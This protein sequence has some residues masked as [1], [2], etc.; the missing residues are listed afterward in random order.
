[1]A[2]S[3]A[4]IGLCHCQTTSVGERPSRSWKERLR[5]AVDAKPEMS[6]TVPTTP[7]CGALDGTRLEPFGGVWAEQNAARSLEDLKFEIVAGVGGVVPGLAHEYMPVACVPREEHR[8]REPDVGVL[9]VIRAVFL[10]TEVAGL[11]HDLSPELDGIGPLPTAGIVHEMRDRRRRAVAAEPFRMSALAHPRLFRTITGWKLP[12]EVS[13]ALRLV[14]R[15]PP[16]TGRGARKRRR[17][18]ALGDDPS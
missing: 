17:R 18:E 3:S 9:P 5:S 4:E 11:P 12:L 8:A 14:S 2:V 6:A 13:S 16:R 10:L 7:L 1:V 15:A